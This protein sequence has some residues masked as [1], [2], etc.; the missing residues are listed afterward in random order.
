L[1][2]AI[3]VT[4]FVLCA[5]G[6]QKAGKRCGGGVEGEELPAILRHGSHCPHAAGATT[7]TTV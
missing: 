3:D 5:I 1:W 4:L 6:P 7:T 2:W